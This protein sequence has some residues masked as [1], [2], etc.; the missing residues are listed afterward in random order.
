MRCGRR[1]I[2]SMMGAIFMK[3]GRAPTTLIIRIIRSA[4][5]PGGSALEGWFDMNSERGGKR[6]R[7]GGDQRS[8]CGAAQV[9][10]LLR[11]FISNVCDER[12]LFGEARGRVISLDLIQLAFDFEEQIARG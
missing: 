2:S 4:F 1:R 5:V 6:E 8:G 10:R 11:S 12:S 7:D 9:T 3:L